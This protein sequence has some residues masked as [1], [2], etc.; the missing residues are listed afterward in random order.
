MNVARGECAKELRL[1]HVYNSLT[2]S[3]HICTTVATVSTGGLQYT[4]WN[5]SEDTCGKRLERSALT[6]GRE[7]RPRCLDISS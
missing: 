6:E 2:V 1:L 7:G 3:T 5:P 4:E